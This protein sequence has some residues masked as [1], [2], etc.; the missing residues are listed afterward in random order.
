MKSITDGWVIIGNNQVH[1]F[2]FS[3]TR[4]EAIDKVTEGIKEREK[5]WRDL[6][7]KNGYNVVR[8]SKIIKVED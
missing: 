2:T 1:G 7:R 3:R 6:T 4:K 5:F 8:A